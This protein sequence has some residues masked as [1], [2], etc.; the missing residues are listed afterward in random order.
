[1]SFQNIRFISVLATLLA[2]A[3]AG[4]ESVNCAPERFISGSHALPSYDEALAQCVAQETAMT[5]PVSGTYELARSCY[6]IAPQGNHG[7]WRHG[8][9]AID[10]VERNSGDRY[11]FEA[12]WMCKPI[13]PTMAGLDHD[14]D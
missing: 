12:L 5:D 6:E 10:V 1:M 14:I 13:A 7:P 9:I 2:A 4:A 11:T 8:R 3:P